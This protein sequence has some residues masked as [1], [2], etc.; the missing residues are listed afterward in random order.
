MKR[1]STL[2][3]AVMVAF[4]A[5]AQG[6]VRDGFVEIVGKKTDAPEVQQFFASYEI[7]NTNGA[8]YSSAKNCIDIDTKKDTIVTVNVYK[9]SPVYGSYTGKLS[10]G[11]TF[12]LTAA[13][14]TAKIGKPTMAYTNSGYAEY[15]YP[16]YVMTCWYEQGVL[17]QVSYSP[18]GMNK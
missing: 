16:G 5:F 1:I 10:K 2:I 7:R 8:K 4:G 6:M 13:Q 3:L 11:L 17:S 12:G 14:V 15:S 18:K 9:S